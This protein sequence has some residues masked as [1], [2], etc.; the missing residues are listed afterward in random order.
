MRLETPAECRR[1]LKHMQVA[2]MVKRWVDL[3]YR[4]AWCVSVDDVAPTSEPGCYKAT[5]GVSMPGPLC[6]VT[7]RLNTVL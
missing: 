7:I 4:D 2:N 5:A 1:V 6:D 3:R